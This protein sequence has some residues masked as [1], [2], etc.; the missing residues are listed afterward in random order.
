MATLFD[1]FLGAGT[2]SYA[3]NGLLADGTQAPAGRYQVLVTAIDT[4]AT[5]TQTAGFDIAV[6]PP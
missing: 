2:F 6:A 5:V 4:L 1:G 3:W